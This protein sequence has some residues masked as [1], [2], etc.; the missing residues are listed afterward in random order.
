MRDAGEFMC[1]VDMS[2]MNLVSH[3]DVRPPQSIH[4]VMN[5]SYEMQ[6]QDL[7]DYVLKE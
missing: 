4:S 1:D 2:C 7:F 3:C 5:S 6:A